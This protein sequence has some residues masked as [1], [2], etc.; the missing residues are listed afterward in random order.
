MSEIAIGKQAY[1]VS[2]RRSR[3]IIHPRFVILKFPDINDRGAASSLIGHVVGW[4]T[5]T[6][7]IIKGTIS[8]VHGNRGAVRAHFKDGSLPGQA[9]GTF[10]KILK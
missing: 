6:G 3:K 10:I 9:F 8:R 2:Y 5:E 1:I 4:E 7:K